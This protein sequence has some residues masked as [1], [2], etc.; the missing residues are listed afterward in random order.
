MNAGTGLTITGSIKDDNGNAIPYAGVSAHKVNSTSDT[1]AVGGGTENF[2]GSQSDSNGAYTLY[3]DAGTWVVEAY[4][5]GFG[6]LGQKIV[7]VGSSSLTGK[8]FSAQTLSLGTITGQAIKASVAQQGVTVRAEGPNGVNMTSTDSSGNYSLKV[9]AGTYTV[10]CSFPGVGESTPLTGVAVTSNTTTSGQDCSLS[11]P[12]TITVNLTDGTN[13]I[14]N[15]FVDVR[16][17]NGRGNGTSVS[18]ASSTDAVYNVVVPPGT[19][20]VR[21]MHP[22]YGQ[23]GET[24][25]VNSTRSITYTASAGQT[26]AVTGTVKVG[27][28]GLAGAWVSLTGV[29]TGQTNTINV[30]GQTSSSG[31]FSINVPAGSYR[32]RANKPGYKSPAETT[33]DVSGAASVGTIT[34][35]TASRT[36]TGTV[37][38]SSSG[39]SGAFVD[40][41]DGNGGFTVSQT[42]DTGAYSLAVDNGT[43]TVR[44]HSIGYEGGPK[45]V[46]VSNNSPSGQNIA[47]S[48]ISGFTVKQERQETIIPTSGGLITN[49]DI[50]SSFKM[51]IPANAL[52]TGSNAGTIKTQNNTAVPTPS[53]GAVLSKNAVKISATDA[54]GQ[55]IKN[56]NDNIIV[57]V[58][59]T[60][61]GIPSGQ[62]ES[63]LVLGVWNDANQSYDTLPTTIDTDAG[64]LTASVSHFSDFVPMFSSNTPAVSSSQSSSNTT[65]SI[66]GGGPVGSGFSFPNVVKPRNQIVYPDGKIVYLDEKITNSPAS[67]NGSK[68][69]STSAG[70][71]SYSRSLSLGKEGSDV[72]SLQTFLENKGFLTIP[73]GVAKG[74]FGNIT[75]KALIKY[76]KSVGIS[77]IGIFGPLTRKSVE[78]D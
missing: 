46:T 72:I 7:T 48:A 41:S 3:V 12:I 75:K 57:V 36:I 54:S 77:P 50:G 39:V 63:D 23:I 2:L 71:A 51:N 69:L 29:P 9:P 64:T 65:T 8:D 38:L 56:L 18:T 10:S 15:A 52:G 28:T 42:D 27:S 14:S 78:G 34:L 13:P 1:T 66:A 17:V 22:A 20:T 55:P 47:L 67:S 76:Q 33:V 44:A 6:R 31:T 62:T 24:L 58:P 45:T 49:S 21:A 70:K 37:T 30:G 19:Y 68:I 74:Y 4:A 25:S 32:V 59:Y 53:T 43:W 26:Y 35:T 60:K 5:P 73:Q 11:A 16:D 61:A 40:A